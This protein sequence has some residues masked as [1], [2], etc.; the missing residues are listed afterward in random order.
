MGA[1]TSPGIRYVVLV[2]LPFLLPVWIGHPAPFEGWINQ[3][4]RTV[5]IAEM[6]GGAEWWREFYLPL[7]FN[8]PNL[9]ADV[10]VL[11][12]LRL[13]LP[14]EW[15]AR[16]CLGLAFAV[17]QFGVILFCVRAGTLDRF[18]PL[19]G[20]ILFYGGAMMWGLVNFTIGLG[21]LFALIGCWLGQERTAARVAIVLGG[22]VLL[23]FCHVVAALLF[24][25]CLGVI[26][27]WAALEAGHGRT[28]LAM[29]AAGGVLLLVLLYMSGVSEDA[30]RAAAGSSIHYLGQGSWHGVVLSKIKMFAKA[31]LDGSG[32]IG[33]LAVSLGLGGYLVAALA[34]GRARMAPALLATSVALVMAA[35]VLP[36]VVGSGA[37]LDYRV[38]YASLIFVAMASAVCWRPGLVARLV[39]GLL[40]LAAAGRIIPLSAATRDGEAVLGDFLA[41]IRAVPQGSVLLLAPGRRLAEIGWDEFWWPPVMHLGTAAAAHGMVV[42][43]VYAVPAQHPLILKPNLRENPVVSVASEAEFA[44]SRARACAWAE[45]G[46]PGRQVYLLVYHPRPGPGGMFPGAPLLAGQEKFRLYALCGPG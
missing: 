31:L 19:L 38:G 2:S 36:D 39:L 35:L 43:D 1:G 24:L 20:G 17:F 6:L 21:V 7:D 27:A 22:V 37:F 41:A 12:L 32:L 13:G 44:A 30:Q 3:L 40:V 14:L 5:I 26:A 45:A 23:W 9:V 8:V 46:M 16:L 33:A 29:V 11:G 18:K 42:P 34:G 15:A 25:G 4:S 10:M 28:G